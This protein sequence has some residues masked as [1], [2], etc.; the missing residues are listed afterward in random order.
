MTYCSS[1]TRKVL[2]VLDEYGLTVDRDD[3][4]RVEQAVGRF[5]NTHVQKVIRDVM[6]HAKMERIEEVGVWEYFQKP[7]LSM[8]TPRGAAARTDSIDFELTYH[9]RN[10]YNLVTSSLLLADFN[11]SELKLL[12]VDIPPMVSEM[13]DLTRAIEACK[14]QS[15]RSIYYLHGVIQR[16][17]QT[18]QG[19]IKEIQK[20]TAEAADQGWKIPDSYDRMDITERRS[21]AD[22]WKDR[23]NSIQIAKALNAKAQE[24]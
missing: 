16:E 11:M 2:D 6:K 13:A 5:W 23:L 14:R 9:N 20:Q 24:S 21:L 15:V 12:T 10:V 22:D 7:V 1:E 18:R 19:R 3:M 17:Y 8:L 4:L